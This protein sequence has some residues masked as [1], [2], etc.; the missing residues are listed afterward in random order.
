MT[1]TVKLEESLREKE[2]EKKSLMGEIMK[3]KK[4]L[5]LKH[6]DIDSGSQ[7]ISKTKTDA[8]QLQIKVLN[9]KLALLSHTSK[10][11]LS[12][13]IVAKQPTSKK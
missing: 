6:R 7:T 3:I 8:Y 10:A 1:E 13:I 5:F 11:P 2:A 12:S 4:E 9:K